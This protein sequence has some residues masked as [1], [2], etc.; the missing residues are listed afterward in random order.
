MNKVFVYGIL[1]TGAG[2]A[3]SIQGDM[4]D[5]GFFPAVVNID[6]PYAYQTWGEVIEVSDKTL[7]NFDHIEGHPTFYCRRRC[8]AYYLDGTSEPVWVYEYQR[9]VTNLPE[10][11]DGNW[12][13]KEAL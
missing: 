4:Y 11:L 2:K 10:I 6:N 8:E 9:D 13:R 1:K 5:V 12:K 7:I 3:A